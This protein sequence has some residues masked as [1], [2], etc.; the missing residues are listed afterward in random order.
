[1]SAIP[2][3]EIFKS[4]RQFRVLQKRIKNEILEQFMYFVDMP[5]TPFI[6]FHAF[7]NKQEISINFILDNFFEFFFAQ[8]ILID[9][10]RNDTLTELTAW[11]QSEGYFQT[12]DPQ[13]KHKKILEDILSG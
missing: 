4:L 5:N 10:L 6:I 9:N 7:T 3:H 11:C 12:W 13:S 8:I 2:L 1:M